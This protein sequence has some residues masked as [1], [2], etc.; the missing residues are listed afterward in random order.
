MPNYELGKIYEVVCLTSGKR[1]VGSTT[2]RLL[3]QRLT[4]HRARISQ[5]KKGTGEHT[6]TIREVMEG[7]NYKMNLLEACP[8]K[9]KDELNA[10][11]YDWINKLECVNKQ[12]KVSDVKS[13]LEGIGK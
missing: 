13:I 5:L 6:S 7:G 9:T 10:K 11:E 2:K 8:C 12:R 1:Y 3:C 4:E